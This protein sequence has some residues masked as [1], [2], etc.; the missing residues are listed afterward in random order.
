[1]R[2]RV[3]RLS[4]K[5]WCQLGGANKPIYRAFRDKY[6]WDPNLRVILTGEI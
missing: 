3:T 6:E 2:K 1:M 4:P 5:E